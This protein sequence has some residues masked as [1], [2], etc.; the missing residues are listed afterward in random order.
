VELVKFRLDEL[1]VLSTPKFYVATTKSI[2]KYFRLHF[3]VVRRL[4]LQISACIFVFKFAISRFQQTLPF[5]E[6]LRL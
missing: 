1:Y 3:L 4:V 2:L 6:I 5:A